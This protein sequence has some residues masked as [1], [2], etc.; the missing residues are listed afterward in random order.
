MAS[1][2]WHA[3][4]PNPTAQPGSITPAEL[5]TIMREK[6]IMK[7]Y[8]VVDVR[9]TDFETAAIAGCLNL[10]AH[11]FYPT[12]STIVAL[13][14]SVPLVIF[15]C[16]SCKAGGRGPRTAGWY[17]DAL[18]SVSVQTSRAVVLQGGIKGWIAG[19]GEDERLTKKM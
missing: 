19:Y 14:A 8:I 11:S 12:V 10:P 15:H 16:N 9:R 2:D 5:A 6:E 4:F 3:A 1:P 17:Q 13:L 18:D 7:D